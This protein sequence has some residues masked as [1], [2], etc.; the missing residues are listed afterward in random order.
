MKPRFRIGIATVVYAAAA[1]A[2]IAQPP[3]PNTLPLKL[4]PAKV[5]TVI[6]VRDLAAVTDRLNGFLAAVALTSAQ[7]E[8]DD[9]D[10]LATK[11]HLPSGV[12]DPDGPV[13]LILGRPGG[14]LADGVV[15]FKPKDPAKFNGNNLLAQG[16][17]KGFDGPDGRYYVLMR[18]GFAIASTKM[19]MLRPFRRL[20]PRDSLYASLDQ[21]QRELFDKSDV[22]VHIPLE[23]WRPMISPV[24][25]MT[26]TAIKYQMSAARR[27]ET[28]AQL[29]ETMLDWVRSGVDTVVEEMTSLTLAASIDRNLI[30]VTHHHSFAR[31]GVVANYLSKVKRSGAKPFE[32]LPDEPFIMMTQTDWRCPAADSLSVQLNRQVLARQDV[33]SKLSPEESRLIREAVDGWSEQSGSSFFM[34]SASSDGQLPFQIKGGHVVDDADKALKQIRDL[35]SRSSAVMSAFLPTGC[36]SGACEN[37]TSSGIKFCEM[38]FNLEKLPIETAVHA[39]KMYGDDCRWQSAKVDRHHVVYTLA[40]PPN[41]VARYIELL[42]KSPVMSSNASVK[43][44]IQ[45]MPRDANLVAVVDLR[46]L[47]TIVPQLSSGAI[48]PKPLNEVL[49]E[50]SAPGAL[51]GWTV[52][53]QPDSISGEL[54]MDTRSVDQVLT[55][56]RVIKRS[57]HV[58]INGEDEPHDSVDEADEGSGHQPDAPAEP[59]DP[60]EPDESEP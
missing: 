39:V 38:R 19:R 7:I 41:G 53:I 56:A 11:L 23:N 9:L 55:L 47:L 12:W 50:A 18:D 20:R 14:G 52:V 1:A 17:S 37:R 46:R 24:V 43:S 48:S 29:G 30:S 36:F 28:D 31:D 57:V 40:E 22:I 45:R 33:D 10:D 8:S 44:V 34:I 16:R 6:A 21:K 13:L 5:S 32:K 60:E 26:M 42:N 4:I 15:C 25:A 51:L 58:R 49:C 27:C 59:E 3:T 35:Q 2:L 54:T